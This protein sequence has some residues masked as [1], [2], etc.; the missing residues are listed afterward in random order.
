VARVE[1]KG[2]QHS[3]GE[4]FSERYA[5]IV[6]PFQRS[7]AWTTEHAGELVDDLLGYLADGDDPVD[8]LNPYFLGSIVLIKGD[9]PE[10]QIV[11][12]QQRL[13]TLTILLAV[14][15]QLIPGE[16]VESITRRL[17]EPADPLNDIPARYRLRP[18]DRD[19]SFFQSYI[20]SEGGIQRLRGQL[21]N[22]LSDSQRN[23][24]ENALLCVE[25]LEMLPVEQRVRL[26]QFIIQRCLLVAV[27]TPDLNS[28]Y[29]IF[30]I[31]NDRGLDLTTA[32]ILKAEIIGR[33][34]AHA[35]QEYTARWEQTD[36]S[37]GTKS[38]NDLLGHIAAM[39]VQTRK[40]TT[41]LDDFRTYVIGQTGDVQQLVDSVIVPYGEAYYTIQHPPYTFAV[42]DTAGPEKANA[43]RCQL[44]KINDSLRWLNEIDHIDWIPPAMRYLSLHH[45]DP[46]RLAQFF[47]ALERL[48]ASLAIR[49]QYAHRRVP[50]YGQ[51]LIAIERGDDLSH[52][53]SP[54]QLRPDECEQTLN[55]LD[56]DLYLMPPMPRNYLLRRLDSLLAEESAVYDRRVLTV[57]HVLPRTPADGSEWLRWF[58]TLEL[59][60]RWTHRLG[61]L[62]LLSR[63]KNFGAS[64]YDFDTKKRKYFATHNGISPFALT[65]QVLQETEWTPE[66]VERRQRELIAKLRDLW[67]L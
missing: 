17:Y 10:A 61:N 29:R 16:F 31:L 63:T 4:I 65:T 12:G 13:I 14:L 26:A 35:Q 18:K 49:R 30:S 11:D 66:V 15:R 6:P 50:R 53:S 21:F 19:A 7:Y 45:N 38:F 8:E 48:A 51:L 55:A 5:F 54:I 43:V 41:I 59:R 60:A 22:D 2:E 28:A 56:G 23:M 24:R 40:R 27:S 47:P 52:P 1:I 57:E 67:R 42:S 25:R 9:R 36:E 64:N 39:Y 62:V 58:P 33:I 46:T 34:P 37:L 20:Q 44:K 32:D 3:I